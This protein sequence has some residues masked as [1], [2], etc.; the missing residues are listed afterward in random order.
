MQETKQVTI[1]GLYHEDKLT[2]ERKYKKEESVNRQQETV[3]QWD[4]ELDNSGDPAR[5]KAQQGHMHMQQSDKENT[6]RR[7]ARLTRTR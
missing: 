3:S 6:H 5:T 1:P 7:E 4:Q 2:G